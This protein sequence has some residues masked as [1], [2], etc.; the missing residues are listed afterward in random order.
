MT[1]Q[2]RAA[3]RATAA[4]VACGLAGSVAFAA[5]ASAQKPDPYGISVPKC[6]EVGADFTVD[7]TRWVTTADTMGRVPV[8]I[9]LRDGSGK[10]F[11][12]SGSDVKRDPNGKS[13]PKVWESFT[14]GGN[15]DFAEDVDVPVDATDQQL[16]QVRVYSDS[17]TAVQRQSAVTADVRVVD[18]ADATGCD[19]KVTAKPDRPAEQTPGDDDDEGADGTGMPNPLD[20]DLNLVEST[21][22]G[23]TVSTSKTEITVKIPGAVQGD[24]VFLSTYLSDNT[25]V[26]AWGDRWFTVDDNAQVTV[27]RTD[28]T[29]LMGTE[30]LV[31]QNE[32]G[33][34]A[35]WVPYKVAGAAGGDGAIRDA[36]DD[37]AV[38]VGERLSDAVIAELDAAREGGNNAS[39]TD[40]DDGNQ[41][42]ADET[43]AAAT[44][45]QS[46]SSGTANDKQSN[47]RTVTTVRRT[48]S[49]G[50]SGA[51]VTT[52]T[53]SSG[54]ASSGSG[55]SNSS[56]DNSSAG[57]ANS[58]GS[59]GAAATGKAQ[60]KNEPK[61]P[62]PNGDKLTDDNRGRIKATIDGTVLNILVVGQ[63]K[64]DWMYIY[65]YSPEAEKLGW[66]LID[67]SGRVAVET[68]E[69]GPGSYKFALVD[70]KGKL[71]GW[72]DLDITDSSADI[73]ETSGGF[74]TWDA[75]YI[76]GALAIVV[77]LVGTALVVGQR[78]KKNI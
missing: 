61:A 74:D 22:N 55:G 43:A 29:K 46:S 14:S 31:V 6:V 64:G 73:A 20:S 59:A 28:D 2:H 41:V 1:R 36:L 33:V 32:Q 48:S 35:G 78:M 21:R 72:T 70:E 40:T 5:P 63:R 47:T 34:L 56:S 60:P 12:R 42:G 77:V 44:S 16:L 24:K 4:L 10:T 75:L 15:G 17:S 26:T 30:K 49:S 11:E 57:S 8:A 45:Q 71:V 3:T 58:G 54:N 68:A 66:A 7:G 65:M 13:D 50:G 69:M 19:G 67:S 62:F 25:R 27:P 39:D 18:D 76:V 37:A 52:P 38:E 53:V 9:E 23:V 51:R